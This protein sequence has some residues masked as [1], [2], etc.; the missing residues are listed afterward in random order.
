M[1]LE[2]AGQKFVQLGIVNTER[3]HGEVL[4]TLLLAL[5]MAINRFYLIKYMIG[6]SFKI[7]IKIQVKLAKIQ[8]DVV[9]HHKTW[10]IN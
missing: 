7:I 4:E 1:R 2:A 10:R 9:E 8:I 6:S 3:M 5:R